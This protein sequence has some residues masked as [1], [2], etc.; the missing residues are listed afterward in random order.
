MQTLLLILYWANPH[1]WFS[2]PVKLMSI[3]AP[4]STIAQVL[5]WETRKSD[6]LG[7]FSVWPFR[8]ISYRDIA[9][10]YADELK[11]NFDSHCCHH[12]M[13]GSS[14]GEQEGQWSVLAGVAQSPSQ[15]PSLPLNATCYISNLP[16]VATKCYMLQSWIAPS[17][18]PL[19]QNNMRVNFTR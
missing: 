9:Y 17:P 3:F 6:S 14:F 1:H 5:N 10:Q 11:S 2:Q 19:L 18:K 12:P 15:A 4:Q 16:P 13:Q 7:L 8:D